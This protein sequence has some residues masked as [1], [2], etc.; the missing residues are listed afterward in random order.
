LRE[1]L[2]TLQPE[3]AADLRALADGLETIHS[4]AV[5]LPRRLAALRTGSESLRSR[6]WLDLCADL[7]DL[8]EE[9]ERILPLV[10]QAATITAEVGSGGMDEIP[11]T[12]ADPSPPNSPRDG[13]SDAIGDVQ[14][15]PV[16]I[17]QLGQS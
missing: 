13:Q 9:T 7:S 2:P 5:A 15:G 11:F 17:V 16:A 12:V 10:G 4:V 1:T 3:G 8:A 14:E 6:A